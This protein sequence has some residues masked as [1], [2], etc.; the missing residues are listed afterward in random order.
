MWVQLLRNR[1]L[2][3]LSYEAAPSD[4]WRIE[5]EDG[6]DR[7][8]GSTRPQSGDTADWAAFN[9]KQR[10]RSETLARS[11]PGPTMAIAVATLDPQVWLL[12]G[13]E[14]LASTAWGEKQAWHAAQGMPMRCR[15]SEMQSGT[16]LK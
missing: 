13:M 1:P 9:E 10:G 5:H 16:L 6:D 8:V 14:K 4:P 12:A 3:S 15:M 7:D 11:N 2:P